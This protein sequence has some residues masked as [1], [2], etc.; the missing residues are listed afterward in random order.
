M[1]YFARSEWIDTPAR[2]LAPLIVAAIQSSSAFRAVAPTSSAAR[3]EFRLDTEI[4]RLQHDFGASPSRVRFTL[5]AYLIET[6]SNRVVAWR[7]LDATAVAASEDPLGGVAAAN[8]AV[9]EVLEALAGFCA[10]AV[11]RLP[12]R[13]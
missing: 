12:G 13:R 5:R 3:G 4:L 8:R 11:A 6:D 10:E 7:D 9:Q 2:M 1:E